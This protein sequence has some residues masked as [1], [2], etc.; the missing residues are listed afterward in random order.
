MLSHILLRTAPNDRGSVISVQCIGSVAIKA[1]SIVRPRS[2]WW[3]GINA[4]SCT[5][6]AFYD[7][8]ALN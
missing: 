6:A 2:T 3:P 5:A 8:A 4:P 7:L 1:G